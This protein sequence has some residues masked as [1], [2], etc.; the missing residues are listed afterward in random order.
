MPND[1]RGN[2]AKRVADTSPGPWKEWHG[3]TRAN[4]A[5]RFIET[6]C[7]TAKGFGHDVP[8]KLAPFQK[9]F[10]R[11][12][13]KPG[14]DIGILA[15]PRGNGK[16]SL[17]GALAVWALFDDD[18]TGSPQVPIV[19]T[20]I[21]QGIK[22][23]YGVAV[24][25]IKRDPALLHRALIFTGVSTPRVLVP[26]NEGELFPIS[27]DPDGLQGLDPSLAIVDEIGFQPVES[28]DSL[29]M[30]AGKRERSTIIGV[31]TPGFDHDNA[32]WHVRKA[33]YDGQ[34][35]RG[36]HFREFAAP[37]GCD[38]GDRKAWRVANPAIKAGFL[39]ESAL[40][41]DAGITIEGHFRL[42]RLG[43]HIE[44]VDSWLGAN[45]PMIW[46]GLEAG[47]DFV[48]GAPTWVGLDVGIKRDSTAVVAVQRDDTGGLH[49]IA[50]FW[51]PSEG[52]PVDVTDVMEHIRELARAYDVQAV[53]FDP[54]F[55]DVPAKWLADEGLPMVEIPQ[56]VERMT[57]ILG[58]LLE[59]I[60]SG[61]LHHD[62]DELLRRHVLNAVPRFNDRGFTLQ[63]SKSRGRIDGA[64]ALALA[65]D[66]A[67]REEAPPEVLMA[68]A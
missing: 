53:S 30:G 25:M 1:R 20:T 2:A 34:T 62:G 23:C 42:F 40:E 17:G 27:N 10:I 47:Y 3:L 41:T 67:L 16:S 38:V 55:F 32:L 58:S 61:G 52:D 7:R 66:R 49:A 48:P 28:W 39:R 35:L 22:S 60:K 14:N 68:W 63:K 46:D 65:V 12:T 5:I 33:Y 56:S 37:D 8:I 57:S 45:G 64:I 24:A 43:Q 31:G 15:T 6:Y 36:L 21:S 26:F 54:R 59:L 51:V 50:R 4:R 44:G 19:A 18:D 29:R 9:A 13:L 11:A